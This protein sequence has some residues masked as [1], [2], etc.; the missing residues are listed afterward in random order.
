MGPPYTCLCW[1][2]TCAS[3]HPTYFIISTCANIHSFRFIVCVTLCVTHCVH[4]AV[5]YHTMQ[6]CTIHL[7][8]L[9]F[10]LSILCNVFVLLLVLYS[11]ILPPPPSPWYGGGGSIY[12]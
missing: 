5:L 12:I 7:L 6:Y 11:A 8:S 9:L 1:P 4:T 2:D 10:L 3:T